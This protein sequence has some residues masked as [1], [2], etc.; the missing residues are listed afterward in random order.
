[1]EHIIRDGDQQKK[2]TMTTDPWGIPLFCTRDEDGTVEIH[3][4]DHLSALTLRIRI[5]EWLSI[6]TEEEI[7]DFSTASS[8]KGLDVKK[9]TYNVLPS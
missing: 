7:K 2:V 6:A 5:G 4:R 1:M 3:Y 8:A 9:D